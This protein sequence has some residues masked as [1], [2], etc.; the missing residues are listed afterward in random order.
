MDKMLHRIHKIPFRSAE[1]DNCQE[2]G[3]EHEDGA[4]E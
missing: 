2:Q 4:I 3:D 1:D